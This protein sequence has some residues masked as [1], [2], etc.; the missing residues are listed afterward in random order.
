[1]ICC[2]QRI[3]W[4]QVLQCLLM[5]SMLAGQ[6]NLWKAKWRRQS[7]CV[8][9][10]VCRSSCKTGPLPLLCVTWVCSCTICGTISM[11]KFIPI[12]ALC[13]L[14]HNCALSCLPVQPNM[15]QST[16]TIFGRKQ[17]CTTC[18]T[19]FSYKA[20]MTKSGFVPFSVA[21]YD[22]SLQWKLHCANLWHICVQALGCTFIFGWCNT[23]K[24]MIGWND[25]VL[26]VVQI[27][28]W[29]TGVL[30]H[31]GVTVTLLQKSHASALIVYYTLMM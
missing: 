21:T 6:T 17:L 3:L 23:P 28:I 30:G 18:G 19:I 24:K 25:F 11:A 31:F 15:A 20:K 8:V 16:S 1:M 5:L 9:I 22:L 10:C 2:A 12:M 13:H 26:L 14:G 27:P 4:L 29:Q 7:H